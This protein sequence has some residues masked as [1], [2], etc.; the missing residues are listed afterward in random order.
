MFYVNVAQTVDSFL[1]FYII[2]SHWEIFK[3][4]HITTTMH[5]VLSQYTLCQL[6]IALAQSNIF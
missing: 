1:F 2:E 4:L 5:T 3:T 6:I